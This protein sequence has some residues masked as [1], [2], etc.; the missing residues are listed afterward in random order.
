M[1]ILI[2]GAAGFIGFSTCKYFLEKKIKVIGI[3]NL[4][5]YYST[6]YKKKGFLN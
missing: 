3:D 2:T 1:N 4:D 5:N 6:L